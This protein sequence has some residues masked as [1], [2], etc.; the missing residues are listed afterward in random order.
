[1]LGTAC[2][3]CARC[4]SELELLKG[5]QD[6]SWS[7]L[8]VGDRVAICSKI[9]E[10]QYMPPEF[11]SAIGGLVN[12]MPS[13]EG[14]TLLCESSGHIDQNWGNCKVELRFVDA[15]KE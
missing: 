5:K 1:M 3:G 14:Y 11:K 4:K 12:A 13:R 8:A 9:E 6:M 15:L 7:I 10:I 2:G